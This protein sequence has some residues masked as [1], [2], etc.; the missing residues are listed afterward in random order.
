MQQDTAASD[1]GTVRAT[2]DGAQCAHLPASSL[3]VLRCWPAGIT[4]P[5]NS[6]LWD[7]QVA[8]VRASV[9]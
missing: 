8:I 4:A 6:P 9:L 3:H 7:A 5:D 2:A 1:V